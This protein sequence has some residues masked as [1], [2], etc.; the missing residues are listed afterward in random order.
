ME[1]FDRIVAP[2]LM[3]RRVNMAANH[4]VTEDTVP[5]DDFVEQL[6]LFTDYSALEKKHVE[7]NAALE[8]ERKLQKATLDIKKKFR[9][10]AILKGMNLQDG[11][12][13][14]GRNSQIGGHKV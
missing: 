11:A 8:R 7:E 3:S 1:L 2:A 13:A 9:K 10:N 4:V 12:T 6:D 14:K 5:K